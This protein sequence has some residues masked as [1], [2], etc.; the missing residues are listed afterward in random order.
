MRRE[1]HH[2]IAIS[3]GGLMV[4]VVVALKV[5]VVAVYI[6]VCKYRIILVEAVANFVL[7]RVCSLF[8][9]SFFLSLCFFLFPPSSISLSL[10]AAWLSLHLVYQMCSQTQLG[11]D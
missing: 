11:M 3:N 5:V 4:K 10:F 6:Y 9:C 2:A 8:V 7:R 1:P